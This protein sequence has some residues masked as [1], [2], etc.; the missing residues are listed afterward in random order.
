MAENNSNGFISCIVTWIG[1]ALV[2]LSLMLVPLLLS[3]PTVSQY[4]G[5]HYAELFPSAWYEDK[6]A[7]SSSSS[8]SAWPKP[9]GL[10][11]GILTVFVGQ[12]CVLVYFG[13]FKFGYV[14]YQFREPQAIQIVGPVSYSFVEG[15]TTHLAQPEG[16]GLLL[17]Y[18]TGTWMYELI[19]PSY[20][21]FEGSIQYVELCACLVLQDFIQYVMHLLEHCVSKE[22]Y[23]Q[24]HKPHH[25][26]INP[27]L[28]DAFNGSLTDTLCM[29]I[30]PLYLTAQL[31]RTV[32]VWT[33]MA[34]GSTYAGWLTMIHSEYAYP[35]DPL[36]RLLGLG[37][38]GDHHVHHKVFHYNYGHLFMWFDQLGGTYKSPS[39]FTVPPHPL[40]HPNV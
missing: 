34:F 35:W 5:T 40:F 15:I 30:L 25:R 33:Y 22:F 9:L 20:Y 16:F 19:P 29:I 32:N 24:S 13:L 27:R 12:L 8:S 1:G 11:L 4:T 37:T 6:T 3:S 39:K 14:S 26:F 23:K 21:S 18:L 7:S 10:C 2:W 38:P 28:F 17:C 31:M 36:F